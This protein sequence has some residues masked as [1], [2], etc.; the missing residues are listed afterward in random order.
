ML[1]ARRTVLGF[2]LVVPRPS[3]SPTLGAARAVPRERR[4][5]RA[6]PRA[7]SS[8]WARARPS[9]EAPALV[10][11]PPAEPLPDAETRR[12][13]DRLPPLAAEPREE[14]F[15]I[16]EA[17]RRR[18][19]PGR[20][21]RAAFPPEA[22]APRPE[23]APAGPLEVLRRM[24]EGDVPLAPH[25][26]I[27]FS[28]PMVRARPRTSDARARGGPRAAVARSR[29]AS[30]AGSARGRS[31]SSPQGRF[32]MATEFRVEVPA[33]T[34]SAAGRDAGGRR[35]LVVLDPAAA[36]PGAPPAG[37]P[38]ES[39]RGDV[40]GVRPGASIRRPSSRRCGS[41]R[42][43]P[44]CRAARLRGRGAR[45]TRS[46]RASRERHSPGAGSPSAPSATLPADAAVSVTVGA[47][48][49]SAEGP[50][51]TAAAQEW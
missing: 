26:S 35:R 50:R 8:A 7:S 51:R 15:A 49:P 45:R 1:R 25:L 3:A 37:R 30:G 44:R 27:T 24:P 21:V 22:A 2:V 43:A 17:S 46:S 13:L 40:R 38:G 23:A 4:G 41:A 14:P 18:R 11:R 36:P 20:T 34:R 29:P 5:R 39:R 47:G 32:P 31:S 16:R 42:A 10:A 9:G 33:G 48:T 28:Q 12:V 6:G 19:A